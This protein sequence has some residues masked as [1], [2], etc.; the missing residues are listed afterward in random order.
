MNRRLRCILF[1]LFVLLVVVCSFKSIEEGL[2]EKRGV[3]RSDKIV[4]TEELT[5][6]TVFSEINEKKRVLYHYQSVLENTKKICIGSDKKEEYFSDVL[7]KLKLNISKFSI[8][9][10]DSDGLPEVILSLVN[11]K[12]ENSYFTILHS[13]QNTVYR[14]LFPHRTFKQI[15]TDGTYRW[16]SGISYS[17]YSTFIFSGDECNTIDLAYRITDKNSTSYY[18]GIESVSKD[19][20]CEFINIQDNKTDAEWFEYS[21]DSFKAIVTSIFGKTQINN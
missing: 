15:K 19:E 13:S 4:E 2:S 11:S 10:F 1:V 20:Y 5:E 16:S 14:F 6:Y 21:I 9:D 3:F 12:G 17:G 18:I 8:I 7:N